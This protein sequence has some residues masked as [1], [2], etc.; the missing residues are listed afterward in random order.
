[1]STKSKNVACS[2]EMILRAFLF[3]FPSF[4]PPPYPSHPVSLCC[5]A[6]QELKLN[7]KE[8]YCLW[9]E[10]CNQIPQNSDLI[11]I[12][13][14]PADD[15][16]SSCCSPGNYL[17]VKWFVFE[18]LCIFPPS[19]FSARSAILITKALTFFL[20]CK[21]FIFYT[22]FEISISIKLFLYML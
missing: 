6:L 17:L 18:R 19:L 9:T 20:C 12:E 4:S 11:S 5:C 2:H 7:F 13:L 16:T 3:Y 15:V 21:V 22:L 8:M 1:M 10:D 14:L